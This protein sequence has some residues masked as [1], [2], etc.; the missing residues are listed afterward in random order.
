MK[1]VV[2]GQGYVGL[3]LA[4][5][6]AEVGHRVIGYEVD[7][8]RVRQL[9]AGHSFA[10]DV[11]SPRLRAVLDSGAYSATT[12]AAAL[13]DFDIALITVPTPLRDGVPDLSYIETCARTVGK[14]LRPGATVVLESTTFP[15]CIEELDRDPGR[16]RGSP[17]PQPWRRA[18]S[19]A[20]VAGWGRGRGARST[21]DL[22]QQRDV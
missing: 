8:H 15:G 13:D 17:G 9:A 3:P 11:A 18:S 16:W 20:D 2:A 14:H 4:V 1:I 12:D 22:R 5:R 6:A 21:A 19:S 10:E 7:V